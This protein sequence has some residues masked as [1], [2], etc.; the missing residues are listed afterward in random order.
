MLASASAD[1][2]V[3]L[4]RAD[5]GAPLA[6]LKGH[7]GVV[8][9]VA[10]GRDGKLLASAG[11]DKTIRLWSLPAGRPVAILQ[12]E[13]DGLRCLRLSPDGATLAAGDWQG[14]V[15][16]WPLR[17]PRPLPRSVMSLFRFTG[18]ELEFLAPKPNLYGGDEGF[19]VGG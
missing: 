19:R 14:R 3:R 17:L 12:G 9:A 13:S 11:L 6:T 2:T 4:W 16:F 1:G 5:S 8:N 10:F 18:W 7:A 15:L